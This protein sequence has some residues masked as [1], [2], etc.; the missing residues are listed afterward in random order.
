MDPID[1]AVKAHREMLR[2]R[3]Q[4][5]AAIV[6]AAAATSSYAVSRRFRAAL[7]DEGMSTE[8]VRLIVERE[9]RK[10]EGTL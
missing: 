1:E 4:R 3:R 6:Q 5:D 8:G 2:A 7:G 10:R 9:R